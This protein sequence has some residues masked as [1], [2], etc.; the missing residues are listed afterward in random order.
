MP[1]NTRQ[2]NSNRGRSASPTTE[3]Q[4]NKKQNTLQTEEPEIITPSQEVPPVDNTVTMEVDQTPDA[5]SSTNNKGKAKETDL[6]PL[7]ITPTSMN[8]DDSS[9]PTENTVVSDKEILALTK[10]KPLQIFFAFCSIKKYK[11]TTLNKKSPILS[12]STA[13]IYSAFRK[14]H[15]ANPLQIQKKPFSRLPF[16]TRK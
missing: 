8:V 3:K 10:P 14:S 15:V 7:N 9:D 5:F 12:I 11:G 1:K 6:P 16:Q 13:W 4:P 2:K